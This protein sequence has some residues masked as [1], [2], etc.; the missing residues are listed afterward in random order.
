[1]FYVHLFI[2]IQHKNCKEMNLMAD[3]SDFTTMSHDMLQIKQV[4]IPGRL[5][6]QHSSSVYVTLVQTDD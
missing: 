2:T 3:P 4:H 1:M 6:E 5:L